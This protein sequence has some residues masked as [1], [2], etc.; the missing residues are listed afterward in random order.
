MKKRQIKNQSIILAKW[1]STT[2]TK[3]I[4]ALIG[5]LALSVTALK[6]MPHPDTHETWLCP[7]DTAWS[8]ACY[9]LLFE[10]TRE[11]RPILLG[12]DIPKGSCVVVG[13]LTSK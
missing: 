3:M 13:V 8:D 11:F 12:Q 4:A 1:Q 6:R 7:D 2:T 5:L 10:A 9:P